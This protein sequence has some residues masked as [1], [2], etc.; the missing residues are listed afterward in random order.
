MCY[1]YN[2]QRHGTAAERYE[3]QRDS[4]RTEFYEFKGLEAALYSSC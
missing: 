2:A 3:T 1:L 4:A